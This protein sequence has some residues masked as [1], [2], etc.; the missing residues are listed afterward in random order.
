MNVKNNP[1]QNPKHI[2][3]SS[4]DLISSLLDLRYSLGRLKIEPYFMIHIK[5]N[6]AKTS[7]CYSDISLALLVA[8]DT[9]SA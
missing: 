4:S 3:Q 1:H 8:S 5:P 6:D 7:T 2:L 9:K